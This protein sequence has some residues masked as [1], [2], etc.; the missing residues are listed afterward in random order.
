MNLYAGK[1]LIVDLS[2]QTVSTEPLKK[3]WIRQYWGSWGLALRYYTDMVDAMI[4]PLAAE[5]PIVIM[6][7]PL[8]GTLVPLTSRLALVSKSPHTGTIFQ[9][10]VGGAFGPELKYAGYDGLIIKGAAKTPVYL[11]I[12][13]DQVTLEDATHLMGK[14]IFETEQAMEHAVGDV[15]A[16]CLA[17]GPAGEK[18]ITYSMIG[19]ESYRQ[20]GRGGTGA[21]FGSKNLKG[22]V[23]RGTG[24]VDVAD[25]KTFIDRISYH[26]HNNLLTE[27]NLWAQTD[28]TAVLVDA[29]NELGIH[30][31]KNY[32]GGICD[33]KDQLNSDAIKEAKIADRACASCPLAC[34][35]FTRVG[36]AEVEGPEYETLCLG[37]S[38]CDVHDL[39]AIIKF[40]RIC[41]DLGLD[42][43]SC[44]STVSMAMEMTESGRHDFGVRFGD[45][46]EYLKLI[47]E[48]ALLSTERGRDLA[49]GAK[50]LAEKYD[51]ADMSME[52]KGLEMP[53]YEPRGNYG[54]G[55]AY[56]TSERGACHLR[57]FP[58]F[59][60]TPFDLDALAQEVVDSQNFNGIKWSMCYCD[61][62][63]TIDT[64][65]TAEL[66]STG[67]GETVT[68]E[69][70]D[71]AGE[72]VWN[73]SRLFNL[74]AGLTIDD[75]SLPEKIL[76]KPLK[77]GPN[78]GKVFCPDDFAVALQTYYK[79]R[80][81]DEKGVPSQAKLDEL[82][83][84]QL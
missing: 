12:V 16:K 47:E 11:K 13:N 19:S 46:V 39:E 26:K 72:R 68:A 58:I 64:K 43:M 59:S 7:G 9:S 22:V 62:W 57:A 10:N 41:D 56:A 28:G 67:L 48:I 61:F 44:G 8:S 52:V 6:T 79:L 3:E 31:T 69:E 15:D 17:I 24:S 29:T 73:L 54:M 53:A 55:L 45:K 38:N 78:A 74:K 82:G 20:F 5:N 1:M 77:N 2:N 23:C 63:G 84:N 50:K 80:G 49:L 14:G 71:Q 25:M 37:G 70:L 66:L 81:W 76:K 18:L 36:A 27:D 35:K 21:L 33:K 42:T 32:T 65:I 4:D 30:P 83:L 40:N 34:G 60:E 51:S 75:D